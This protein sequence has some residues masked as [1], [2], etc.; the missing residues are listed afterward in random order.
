MWGCGA[1]QAPPRTKV[2]G[3]LS[4]HLWFSLLCLPAS[5]IPG[6]PWGARGTSGVV[7][8]YIAASAAGKTNLACSKVRIS[9]D[10]FCKPRLRRASRLVL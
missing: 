10:R 6:Y 7:T 3:T 9:P 5:A 2:H 1:P 8:R 4:T